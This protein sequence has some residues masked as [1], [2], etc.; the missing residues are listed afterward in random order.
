MNLPDRGRATP[1]RP[2]ALT[3]AALV[4]SFWALAMTASCAWA[5]IVIFGGDL[6]SYEIDGRPATADEIRP[7]MV[8]SF[9][10]ACLVLASFFTVAAVGLWRGRSWS[11]PLLVSFWGLMAAGSLLLSWQLDRLSV[12]QAIFYLVFGSL[13]VGASYW[14]L[15]RTRAVADYYDGLRTSEGP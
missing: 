11:R 2:R 5:L 13:F 1:R 12:V 9:L 7:Y 15:Y 4:C 8:S 10:P 14:T 6:G 3:A